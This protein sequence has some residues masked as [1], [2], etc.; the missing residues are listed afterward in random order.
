MNRRL[1]QVQDSLRSG[2]Y[3]ELDDQARNSFF[4]KRYAIHG[5]RTNGQRRHQRHGPGV[6]REGVEHYAHEYV[7][8]AAR[9]ISRHA[10]LT[11]GSTSEPIIA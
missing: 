5:R 8:R 10:S 6:P 4:R 9:V 3:A 7:V 1:R 2:V 11:E